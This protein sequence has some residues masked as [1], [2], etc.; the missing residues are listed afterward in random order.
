[1]DGWSDCHRWRLW[2]AISLDMGVNCVHVRR[3]FLG[4][5]EFSTDECDTELLNWRILRFF[6]TKT[7]ILE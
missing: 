2:N 6:F 3:C 5:I 1:M 4:K 7:A